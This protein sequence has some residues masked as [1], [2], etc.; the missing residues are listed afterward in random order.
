MLY[1]E[2][3]K[4][5]SQRSSIC[6]W[7]EAVFPRFSARFETFEYFQISLVFRLDFWQPRSGEAGFSPFLEMHCH[8]VA[9]VCQT[10]SFPSRP[11][12][13]FEIHTPCGLPLTQLFLASF[14]YYWTWSIIELEGQAVLKAVAHFFT[15][16]LQIFLYATIR[17]CKHC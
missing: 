16:F 4:I 2:P 15:S 11:L 1:S 8:L 9:V 17:T 12:C 3:P 13:W 7:Q 6:D 10:H 5:K 14:W